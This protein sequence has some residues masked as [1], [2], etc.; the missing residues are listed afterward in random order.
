MAKN[1]TIDR[2]VSCEA[3]RLGNGSELDSD[4]W[5]RSKK[6]KPESGKRKAKTRG[7]KKHGRK[8]HEDVEGR[9]QPLTTA[10][11]HALPC[12]YTRPLVAHTFGLD[13]GPS[14]LPSSPSDA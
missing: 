7:V 12:E 5:V 3:M 14:Y 13:S 4:I 1:K 10:G 6:L 11:L 8:D 9:Q 2:R